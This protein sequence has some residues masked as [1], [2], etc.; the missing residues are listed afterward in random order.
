MIR[1]YRDAA[2]QLLADVA[3]ILAP[4]KPQHRAAVEVDFVNPALYSD[5]VEA[6]FYLLNA[7]HK[8]VL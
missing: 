7:R 3:Q 2:R 6:A 8:A 5:H 1:L 4:E